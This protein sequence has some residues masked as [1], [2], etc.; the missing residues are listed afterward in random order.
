MPIPLII[1]AGVRVGMV[2]LRSQGTKAAAQQ[3]G[4]QAAQAGP[5]GANQMAQNGSGAAG[6]NSPSDMLGN[7]ANLAGLGSMIPPSKTQESERTR[8]PQSRYESQL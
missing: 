1:M 5:R 4:K 7:A 8:K 3:A 6:K 2:L